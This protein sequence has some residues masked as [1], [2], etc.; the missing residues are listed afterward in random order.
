MT[1]LA[2]SAAPHQLSFPLPHTHN[3]TVHM[4]MTLT[5]HSLLL[6]LTTRTPET[7]SQPAP[8]GSFIYALPS[9]TSV[10]PLSTAIY[11]R[12]QTLETATRIGKILAKRLG[13]PVYVGN[14]MSFSAAGGGGMVEEEMEGV[15]RVVECVMEVAGREK[16]QKEE[17]GKE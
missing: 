4:H 3:T 10:Q 2:P 14:S 7:S 16:Q 5:A 17:G 1:A 13:L 11:V 6:F 12:E 15:R 9:R 8:L